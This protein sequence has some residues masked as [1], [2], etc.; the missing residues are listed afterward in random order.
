MGR[1]NAAGNDGG[2]RA[3]DDA[4]VPLPDMPSATRFLFAGC[5]FTPWNAVASWLG[6]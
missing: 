3:S 5:A 1:G 6:L 2:R 4:A